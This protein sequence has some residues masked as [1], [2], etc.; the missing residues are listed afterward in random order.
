MPG[1]FDW[2]GEL[3][4]AAARWIERCLPKYEPERWNTADVQPRNN[5]YNYACDMQTNT[6]AQ[7][8]RASGAQYN[9]LECGSVGPAA[10]RD[11]LQANDTAD[12]GCSDCCHTVALVMAPGWDYHWY[13]KDRD[14]TWSHKPGGTAATNLDNGGQ[15]IRDP[16]NANRG[17]YKVFCG[18]YCVCE[19]SVHIS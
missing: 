10:E 13:R 5:C 14:G 15:I 16:R 11:G 17:S 12:C 18:F 2:V 1:P 7:P 19:G 4:R 6:F 3:V 9:A 8:G